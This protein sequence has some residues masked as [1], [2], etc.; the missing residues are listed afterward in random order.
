MKTSLKEARERYTDLK[1]EDVAKLVGVS[2][3]TY[4]KW[5]QG[6]RQPNGKQIVLLSKALGVTTDTILGTDFSDIREDEYVLS[7]DEK[8][9]VDAYRSLGSEQRELIMDGIVSYAESRSR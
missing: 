8:R 4:Q 6:T 9:L 1:Q 5:E 2:V 3:S 7:D